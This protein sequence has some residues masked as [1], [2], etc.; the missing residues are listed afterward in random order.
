VRSLSIALLGAPRIEVDGQPLAVDTRKATAVLAFL[1]LSGHS[2]ARAVLAELLWPDREPE[3]SRSALRRTLSTLRGGLGEERLIA[4]RLTVSLDLEGA[5]LDVAE[6][7]R[8]AGDPTAGIDELAAA[9]ALHRG[10][11]L[12]GFSLRDSVEF[13]DW[14]RGVQETM[15]RER[16]GA[17]DRLADALAGDGRFEEAIAAARQRLALDSLHEPT[18]RRLIDLYAR[19]GRRGDALVQ[20]REC[21]R[22][23]DRELGVS[24]LRETTDLY[25]AINGGAAPAAVRSE[26]A[27]P[28]SELDLVGRRGELERVLAAYDGAG[29]QGSLMVIEGESG[30]G[31]TR[32]AAEARARI[33]RR[34]GRILAAHPHP[35]EQE[36]AYGVI[37]ALLREAIGASGPEHVEEALRADAARLLP[38]LGAP[39]PASLDEPGARLR[40]LEAI[41]RLILASFAE[42][43]GTIW[44]DDLQWCDPASLEALG[45][46]ARRLDAHPLLLL[47][48]RRTDE[49]DP[50]R[51][52]AHFAQLGERL[53]LGRL[54]RADVISLALR[55]GLDEEAAARVYRES[56]GLPLYVAE[57][58]AP[59]A[60][61]AGGGVR[62]AFEARLDAVGEAA[63]QVLAAAALIGRTFDADTL[64]LAS[65]RSEDEVA[66]ALEELAARGLILERDATYDF[67]HERLRAIAQERIGLARRRLLHRRIAQAL[68]DRHDDPALVARHLE[69]AGD[70]AAAALAHAAAG[71]HARELSA[72]LEAVSHFEAAIA[73]GHPD[74][75]ALQETIGDLHVLRGA[76][77]DALAAYAAAAAQD[78][79]A[80]AGRLEHKLGGV[81]ERRGEWELAERHYEDALALGGEDAVVQCDRSRVAWRRG[82]L[83]QARALGFEALA[84]AEAE[85][86]TAAA[87]QANN[88]LGLL[89]AGRQHLERSLELAGELR[90]PAIRIAALNN[91][92]RE[93]SS[94]GDLTRAEEL[95]REALAQCAAEGDLHHEAA[96]RNNLADVLHRA[97][98]RDAAME[99]LKLAVSAFATI[100]REDELAYPGIWSLAEW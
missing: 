21:V 77:R 57:L 52:Y 88:I 13:D 92:A 56:E 53:T 69:L 23:L 89:G 5:F 43:P 41:S 66:A 40:F 17:L 20:Y 54:G 9:V 63:A 45:Y 3:R 79:R 91:L 32:L 73:L 29:E 10:E 22:E 48:A 60:G 34:G 44:I 38:E 86:A 72:A 87:A 31:K 95:L 51:I 49:P 2:H 42:G 65:G 96:L 24:P 12:E 97:G 61:A 46:L 26:P 27:A 81:H 58:L 94:D 76:Y 55:I 59:G 35:G 28:A 64:R 99:E 93:H 100:G 71:A 84:L 80:A 98:H 4:D 67:G 15:R 85:G 39:T 6:F 70:D 19:A 47:G 36:L 50:Q 7:R 16:A 14:Q 11:L 18:H 37:A 82:E 90:D 75:A 30:V 78:D 83:E 1:A 74:S 8:L 68:A 62:G 25:N 33:E